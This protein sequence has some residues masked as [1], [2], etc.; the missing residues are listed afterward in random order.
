MLRDFIILMRPKQYS[1][2]LFVLAPLFFSG[3]IY[4]AA[5]LLP[6]VAA[7]SMFC[8][9]ASAVYILND[10]ADAKDDEK[11]PV[12]KNRPIAA[13]RIDQKLA[14]VIAALFGCGALGGAFVFNIYIGF[15]MTGYLLL[16]V[17]YSLILKK[18]AIV[19][20]LIIA[21]GFVLRLFAGSIA[22]EIKLSMWIILLTFLLAL[23]LAVAKRRDDV[24]LESI[25]GA[26]L[27]AATKGYNEQFINSLLSMLATLVVVFYVMYVS[28]EAV[29]QLW[30]TSNLYVSSVFIIGSIMRY[31]QL[32]LVHEASG[33]PTRVLF[34]DRFIQI[35]LLGF[36]VFYSTLLYLG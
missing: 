4:S 17:A 22:A 31:L 1:K 7:M 27:R 29:I 33:D 25:N 18:M 19:D 36:L 11:H 35:N 9:L 32:T 8:V 24:M 3:K 26:S 30:G 15:V 13:G 23:F 6:A 2:N 34:E 12:K 20:V 10:C 21:T 14:L 16:N 5:Y 28:S